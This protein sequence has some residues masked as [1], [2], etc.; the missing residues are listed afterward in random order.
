[1]A[2]DLQVNIASEFKGKKAFTDAEKALN[3]L[4]GG[5]KK[6]AGALGVAYGTKAI[7]AYGKASMKAAADGN[8]NGC[9]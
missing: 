1:M 5:A 6:L 4:T 8:P 2:T 7:L 3:K 9:S